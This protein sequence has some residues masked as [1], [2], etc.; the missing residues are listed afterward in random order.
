MESPVKIQTIRD[1]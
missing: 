1:M